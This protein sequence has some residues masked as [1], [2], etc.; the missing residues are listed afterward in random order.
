V[1][2]PIRIN[3]EFKD[4]RI[5]F[6][7]RPDFAFLNRWQRCVRNDKHPIRADAVNFASLACKRFQAHFALENYAERFEDIAAHVKNNPRSEVAGL[8]VM[9]CD[10]FAD[11]DVIG[12]AH[13]RRSWCNNLILDYLAAHPWIAA[14]PP[15][16]ANEVSG[17]GTSMLYFLCQVAV[18]LD[19][20]AMWGEA[21]Q[22]S[23]ELYQ[24]LFNLETVE[25][26]LYI[27]KENLIAFAHTMEQKWS[28]L[29]KKK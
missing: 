10:W 27:P 14:P 8:V 9:R 12:L 28:S 7:S 16:Y 26:L 24:R 13:F 25:D 2:A 15:G 23:C 6:V 11:A 3:R 20:R 5:E 4:A 29:E 1:K 21:T 17:V 18:R 19:C 22:N